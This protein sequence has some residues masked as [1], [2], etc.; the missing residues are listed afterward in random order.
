MSDD[1][2]GTQVSDL[3]P[4][5]KMKDMTIWLGDGP[6]LTV[7]EELKGRVVRW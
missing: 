4:L 7:P 2:A 6:Q 3:S 1:I 5:V